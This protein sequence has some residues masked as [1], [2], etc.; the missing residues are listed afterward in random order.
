MLLFYMYA[1][2]IDHISS[3]YNNIHAINCQ[4]L[5]ESNHSTLHQLRLKVL[6][7]AP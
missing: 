3:G 2:N 4:H 7:S 6:S 1:R 5:G